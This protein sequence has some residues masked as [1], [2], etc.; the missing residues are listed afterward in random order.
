MKTLLDQLDQASDV[1]AQRKA[2]A[3]KGLPLFMRE[4]SGNFLKT[5]LDTDPEDTHTKGMKMGVLTIIE[6]DVA[7]IHSIP[8]VRLH[9]APHA[10]FQR[11]VAKRRRKHN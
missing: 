11:N 10:L 1:L 4:K 3:L 6:D 7:T 5:C 9:Y 2:T 8:N